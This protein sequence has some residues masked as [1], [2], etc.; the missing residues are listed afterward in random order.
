MK[1]KKL[2][3]T[4]QKQETVHTLGLRNKHERRKEIQDPLKRNFLNDDI[5]HPEMDNDLTQESYY[6]SIRQNARDIARTRLP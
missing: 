4:K 2:I 1:K 5:V 3:W 6:S